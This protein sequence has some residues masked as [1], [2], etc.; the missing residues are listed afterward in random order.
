MHELDDADFYEISSMKLYCC[1]DYDGFLLL[2]SAELFHQL[3]QALELLTD[4]SARVSWEMSWL[5][6][7]LKLVVS[8]P[9]SSWP[10]D[11]IWR[12]RYMYT[13]AH[14]M[15]CCLT[16]PSQ[17]LGHCRLIIKG[18]LWHSTENN[19][20]RSAHEIN[21]WHV[22]RD[23]TFK[24]SNTSLR[25]QWV[26]LDNW[27]AGL[28]SIHFFQFN[29]NSRRIQDYSIQFQFKSDSESFNSIPIHFLSIQFKFY[30]PW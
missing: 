12:H 3:T 22:F 5:K 29:S 2:F 27:E 21:L 11:A 25:S 26:N 30:A 4:D 7:W 8:N 28:W 15:V 16:A 17:Y 19:F 20:T 6:K 13:L 23:Y 14:V 18:V 24:F 1:T 10:S 9:N